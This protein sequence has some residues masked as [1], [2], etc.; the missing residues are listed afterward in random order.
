MQR[1]TYTQ[2]NTFSV[3]VPMVKKM[4]EKVG[5]TT[6]ITTEEYI[7]NDGDVLEVRLI[8]DRRQYRYTPTTEGNVAVFTMQGNELAG[9]YGIEVNVLCANG[10][11]MRFADPNAVEL[12]PYTG[13]VDNFI[14]GEVSLGAS[15]FFAMRGEKGDP[16]DDGNGIV[17]ITKTGTSGLVDTYTISYTDGTSSTFTVTNGEKG[18]P[19]ATGAT[20]VGILG[21][22]KTSSHGLVDTYTITFSDRTTTTYQVTNGANGANG[23]NGTNGA[24]GADGRGITSIV[25]TTTTQ[26]S[27]G[28]NVVTITMTDGTTATFDVYNGQVG[29]NTA[30][31]GKIDGVQFYKVISYNNVGT[32]T[33]D[34]DPETGDA[35]KLY[36]DILTNKVYNYT[37]RILPIGDSHYIEINK[38]TILTKHTN[39][40]TGLVV[41]ALMPNVFYDFTGAPTSLTL[42][43]TAPTDGSLPIY[44]G[45]FTAG[46]SFAGLTVPSGVTVADGSD[47]P[48]DGDICEFSILD[49][50]I[51][52]RKVGAAS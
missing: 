44:A 14:V 34:T 20:G 43:L 45:K 4:V 42:T 51:V 27:G 22:E 38:Q 21:I 5:N 28:R 48:A 26:E 13:I 50:V 33:F 49:D 11:R 24:D 1:I 37:P 8:G 29:E 17:S 25:E 6:T 12:V 9:R 41:Q 32:P 46:T 40:A 2:G 52:V 36:V 23:T 15:V 19:G 18:D 39:S 31:F 3:S 16:G 10:E 7:P 30:V 35:G 47:T